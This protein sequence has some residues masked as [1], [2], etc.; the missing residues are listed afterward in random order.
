M[1]AAFRVA[2]QRVNVI[3]FQLI[4]HAAAAEQRLLLVRRIFLL[5]LPE[6][7]RAEL[8]PE[9]EPLHAI[10]AQHGRIPPK[11]VQ[12]LPGMG[13]AADHP[14]HFRAEALKRGQLQQEA[15][16][17]KIKAPVDNGFKVGKDL[18]KRF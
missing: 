8:R 14:G 3:F 9:V 7:K 2:I 13:I 4:I 1:V 10:I 15:A 6:E 12:Q 5:H 17:G 11:P 16:H 18:P